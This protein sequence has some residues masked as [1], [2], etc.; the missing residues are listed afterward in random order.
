MT[1]FKKDQ[2]T[3]SKDYQTFLNDYVTGSPVIR[4]RG[5][6]DIT[7]WN[8]LSGEE[9]EMAKQ[10]I[11]DAL[12]SDEDYLI[13]AVAQFRDERAIP[14]LQ[15]TAENGKSV[16]ARC[17]AAKTLHDWIGYDVY[18][19]KL[20]DVY[21]SNNQ[22]A[23]INL[24]FWISELNEEEALTYFWKAMGDPD[25]FVRFNACEAL[26]HYYGIHKIHNDGLDISYYTGQEVFQDKALFQKRKNELKDLIKSWKR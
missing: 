3:R 11:L 19:E 2:K 12:P 9:L 16:Y 15:W 7:V 21:R 20:D 17:Y 25:H 14:K 13:R 23:K 10:K 5:E 4:T 22:W 24:R 18:F 1:V 26:A 6:E 8:R